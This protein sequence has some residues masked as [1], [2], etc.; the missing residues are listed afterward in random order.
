[1]IIIEVKRWPNQ[2]L[3]LHKSLYGLKQAAR[4]WYQ[5]LDSLLQTLGFIRVRVDYGVWVRHNSDTDPA[6]HWQT[7]LS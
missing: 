1:M 2:V 7:L 6:Y 5:T 3:R 4:V